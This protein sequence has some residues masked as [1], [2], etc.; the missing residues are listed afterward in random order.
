MLVFANLFYGL[1]IL[2]PGIDLSDPTFYEAT[3]AYLIGSFFIVPL[4]M[5]NCFQYYY[6]TYIKE[7]LQRRFGNQLNNSDTIQLSD[8]DNDRII[9]VNSIPTLPTLDIDVQE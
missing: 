3:C 8:N 6:Y 4:C 9:V 5:I 7:W 2:L 1:S